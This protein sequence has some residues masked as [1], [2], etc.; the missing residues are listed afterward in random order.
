MR[1]LS[2][3]FCLFFVTTYAL[4][5]TGQKVYDF[6]ELESGCPLPMIPEGEKPILEEVEHY[7]DMS[8]QLPL[9]MGMS[10]E[11][12]QG[13]LPLP[14]S[15]ISERYFKMLQDFMKKNPVEIIQKFGENEF[16]Q[17]EAYLW[18]L[19]T[20]S[21]KIL[22]EPIYEDV[23]FKEDKH[24]Y[25]I[26]RQKGGV[27]YNFFDLKGKKKLDG[28]YDQIFFGGKNNLSIR[29]KNKA[30]VFAYED[31]IIIEPEFQSISQS[32]NYWI[33]EKNNLYGLLNRKG[34]VLIEPK[35][36]RINKIESNNSEEY[37]ALRGHSG[38]IIYKGGGQLN[39]LGIKFDGLTEAHIFDDRYLYYSNQL[40]DLK[41]KIFLICEKKVKVKRTG[42]DSNL[43]YIQQKRDSWVFNEKGIIV[44]DRPLLGQPNFKFVEDVA[45]AKMKCKDE[46]KTLYGFMKE[47]L[48]NKKFEWIGA[49]KYK[50]LEK[51]KGMDLFI[52]YNADSKYGV[53]DTKGETI[54]PFNYKKI[55]STGDRFLVYSDNGTNERN[56]YDSSGKILFQTSIEY[57]NIVKNKVGYRAWQEPDYKGVVLNEKFEV[58]YTKKFKGCGEFGKEAFWFE[59]FDQPDTYDIIDF[60]GAVYPIVIDGKPR[61]DLKKVA[62][63]NGTSFFYLEFSE[64]ENFI[65]NSTINKAYP[66][67]SEIGSVSA[68]SYKINKT[69]LT[70]NA[71]QDL[72]GL[73]DTL[74]NEI[75]PPVFQHIYQ[76][77]T[78]SSI[79]KL[80]I[81]DRWQVFTYN[82]NRILDE[83]K[84]NKITFLFENFI[85]VEKDGKTGV[86]RMNGDVLIPFKYKAI[87]KEHPNKFRVTTF[88]GERFILGINLPR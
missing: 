36:E 16:F 32:G 56:V 7:I 77:H 86:V 87:E 15:K 69:F 68:G 20:K 29:L 19:R 2:L 27:G 70:F 23:K 84:D 61:T 38:L 76:D 17:G 35:Y 44:S 25:F 46:E 9:S 73:I 88:E 74:G 11:E 39:K 66:I 8:D 24:S 50:A 42:L 12:D 18:G 75:L 31:N 67:N 4:G 48:V 82:G 52:G 79:L 47:G 53:I 41:N 64:E 34:K 21:G 22:I 60:S 30:G 65:Y 55:I 13:K 63:I 54:I 33:V 14:D 40:I 81:N 26:A 72:V 83:F 85:A 62:E 59:Q 45:I 28:I 71:N 51:A 57:G 37:F 58:I 3:I 49:S 6:L 43:F 10:E 5:Q 1:L 78:N 80:K